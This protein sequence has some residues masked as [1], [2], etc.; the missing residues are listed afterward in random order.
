MANYLHTASGTLG[1][2]PWS[3]TAKSV[4]ASNEAAAESAWG[5]GW[6]AMWGDAA[7]KARYGTD[8]ELTE[9]S[10]STASATWK[11][12]TVTR[13]THA[14]AGTQTQSL[15]YQTAVVVTLRSALA[16]KYGHG[17]WFLPAPAVGTLATA[18]YV[19]SAAALADFVTGVNAAFA[20]WHGILTLQVLHRRGTIDGTRGAL[21]TD[22]VISGDI[23]E[24]FVIQKRRADKAAITRSAIVI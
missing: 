17:R 10:T 8:A 18:G 15:P 14:L 24:K 6:A 3:V 23:A 20:A 9:T 7:F 21:T 16:T 12:T 5:G 11:Q 13:T 1:G 22:P 2:F 19:M 4:S